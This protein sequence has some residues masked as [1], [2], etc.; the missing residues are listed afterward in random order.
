[1]PAIKAVEPRIEVEDVQRSAR[2]YADM[3]GFNTSVLWPEGS[4]EFAILHRDGVRLQLVKS[5][6]EDKASSSLWLDVA[7]IGDFLAATRQRARIE[8]G[9]EVFFYQRREFAFRDPDD[10]LII[11][12]EITTDPPTCAAG[13]ASD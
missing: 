10:H 3:L 9:P 1:M 5:S 12:S 6:Q 2:F 11:L 7:D 13:S 4:P 8:W